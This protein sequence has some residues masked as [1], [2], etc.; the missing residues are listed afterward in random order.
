MLSYALVKQIGQSEIEQLI[1]EMELATEELPEAKLPDGLF[2]Q[3]LNV[4]EN[5]LRPF[6]LSWQLTLAFV[7]AAVSATLKSPTVCVLLCWLTHQDQSAA[8]RSSFLEQLRNEGV[9]TGVLIP[10]L[11]NRMGFVGRTTP[12]EIQYW[13][14]DDPELH[15]S[16]SLCCSSRGP[17]AHSMRCSSGGFT[18]ERD[19][20]LRSRVLPCFGTAPFTCPSLA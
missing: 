20:A 2:S 19:A 10:A 16:S 8:V 11:I 15:R 3:L 9:V 12:S 17:L 18:A 14:I 4:D 5:N 1:V 6:L 7:D 13:A